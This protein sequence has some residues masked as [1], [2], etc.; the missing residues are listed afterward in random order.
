MEHT[1][2]FEELDMM[3]GSENLN[4]CRSWYIQALWKDVKET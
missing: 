3:L 1:H 4:L 2:P